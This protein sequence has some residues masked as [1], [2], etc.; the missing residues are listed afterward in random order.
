DLAGTAGVGPV[1]VI[2]VERG[3]PTVQLG[4]LLQ[5]LHEAGIRVNLE[6]PD[7]LADRPQGSSS[8]GLDL[9]AAIEAVAAR[10]DSSDW[11]QSLKALLLTH[12]RTQ[13]DTPSDRT[14]S[15]D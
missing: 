3:K 4:K 12:M 10:S 1:F 5:V 15:H 8:A 13:E 11:A 7:T 9:A 6:I 2:D 14:R